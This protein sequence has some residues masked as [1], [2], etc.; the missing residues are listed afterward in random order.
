MPRADKSIFWPSSEL[1]KVLEFINDNFDEYCKNRRKICNEAVKATNICRNGKS[2]YN[3][4]FNLIRNMM[5]SEFKSSEPT[6]RSIKESK[7]IRRLVSELYNKTNAKEKNKKENQKITED[8]KSDDTKMNLDDD[9]V[10]IGAF[11]GQMDMFFSIENVNEFCEEKIQN[12][13]HYATI[14]KE[15]VESGLEIK[16]EE[17][18]QLL[19]ECEKTMKDRD[20]KVNK[21]LEDLESVGMDWDPDNTP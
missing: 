3:K 1:I 5:I 8:R 7:E 14:S 4:L 17:I 13:N 20:S 6:S 15:I 10:T 11:T 16:L 19:S 9:K 21:L 18:L 2:V 12:V